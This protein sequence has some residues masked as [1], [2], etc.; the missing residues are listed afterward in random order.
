VIEYTYRQQIR[1]VIVIELLIALLGFGIAYTFWSNFCDSSIESCLRELGGVAPGYFI[2]LSV[3]RPF[4]VTPVSVFAYLAGHTFGPI[5]GALLTSLGTTLSA[6]VVYGFAKTIG[7]KLVNPW[8]HANLP[9]TLKFIRSQ[10]WKIIFVL[11]LIP[12]IP[13]DL[14]SF[15]FG[16]VDFRFKYFVLATFL[17]SIPEAYMLANFGSPDSTLLNSTLSAIGIVCVFFVMPALIFEI[18]SR[19]RGTSL[20]VRLQAM[21]QELIF[22]IKVN[23]SIVKRNA[24]SGKKIPVLLLYGFFSSR[25][26]LTVIERQLDAKGYEV[27][28]FNLG[29]LLGVFFTKGITDTAEFIDYKLKRQFARH[30]F[31]QVNIVAH[32]KGGLVALWWLLKLGGDKHCKKIITM[33]TPYTGTNLTWLALITPLG[34]MW[35]DMWQMRPHSALL[36]ELHTCKIPPDVEIH[37]LYSHKDAVASGDSGCFRPQSPSKNVFPVP[38][39]HVSHFE[40][41]YRRTVGDTLAKIL[42]PPITV[43]QVERHPAADLQMVANDSN[44]SQ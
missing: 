30:Q 15:L 1:T 35:K 40:F 19:K 37:C 5:A 43:D 12:I 32:S 29:G 34:F 16:V 36:K 31:Q 33:G 4:I 7:K 27:L 14:L 39:H 44:H 26:S 17:G 8:L 13:F 11:R 25:R 20:W 2:L 41:L 6:I 3:I 24:L 38:M 23:N 28:S 9:Q 18:V 10:D 42:G 21:W 22:E